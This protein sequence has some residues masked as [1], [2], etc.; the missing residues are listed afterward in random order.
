MR[1]LLSVICPRMLPFKISACQ[2]LN[3]DARE[4]IILC[5]YNHQN[6][7]KLWTRG[8]ISAL[9]LQNPKL[10]VCGFLFHVQFWQPFMSTQGT[11]VFLSFH[12][13]FPVLYSLNSSK[14]KKKD[15][16]LWLSFSAVSTSVLIRKLLTAMGRE[17]M[18]KWV[19]MTTS[20]QQSFNKS[21][22]D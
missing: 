11:L 13:L 20:T 22:H 12:Q 1:W 19:S 14:N 21:K 3:M 5:E 4:I 15:F 7:D 2:N 18:I 8:R 6:I 9:H 17:K 16:I 10:L